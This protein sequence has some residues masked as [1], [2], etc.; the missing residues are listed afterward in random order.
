MNSINPDRVL[1]LRLDLQGCRFEGSRRAF[2]TGVLRQVLILC[3]SCGSASFGGSARSLCTL[4]AIGKPPEDRASGCGGKDDALQS[5]WTGIGQRQSQALAHLSRSSSSQTSSSWRRR[6]WWAQDPPS[7]GT[8][9]ST[10]AGGMKLQPSPLTSRPR[11][12]VFSPTVPA[13]TVQDGTRDAG[14]C[15]SKS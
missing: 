13:R 6:G 7:W 9:P 10:Q 2:G 4:M 1:C 3:E 12:Q 14:G 5:L 11:C 8:R 15:L